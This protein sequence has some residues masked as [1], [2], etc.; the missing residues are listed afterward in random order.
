MAQKK[1]SEIIDTSRSSSES[2]TSSVNTDLSMKKSSSNSECG[3]PEPNKL[4]EDN[5]QKR[6]KIS[7]N[8]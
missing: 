6:P 4:T 2:K 1:D 7:T 5:H 3:T 8:E